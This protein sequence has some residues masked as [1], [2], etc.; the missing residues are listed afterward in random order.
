[1]FAVPERRQR[2]D[3]ALSLDSRLQRARLEI[4]NQTG[5]AGEAD[6][7]PDGMRT[8]CRD[9]KRSE[10]G[11]VER[12]Q[13]GRTVYKRREG[14][15]ATAL[16]LNGKTGAATPAMAQCRP[17]RCLNSWIASRNRPMWTKAIADGEE[18]LGTKWQSL[19]QGEVIASDNTRYRRALRQPVHE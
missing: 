18:L 11:S 10:D 12:H 3:G 19:L 17:D 2:T 6:V 15:R 4:E 5:L 13:I 7:P 1:M 16:C 8:A 9:V 14:R